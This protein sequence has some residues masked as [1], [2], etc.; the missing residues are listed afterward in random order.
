[1]RFGS[2]WT[3]LGAALV[4]VLAAACGGGGSTGDRATAGH[5]AGPTSTALG[6]V[7]GTFPLTGMPAYDRAKLARQAVAVKIDNS[8][9]A[10]PQ[11]GIDHADVVYEEYTEGITRFIVVFQSSDAPFVGPV[12]S[13]RPADPT[14]IKPLGGPLA[15]SGGSPAV[16]DVVKSS[17]IRQITENDT[18]TLK[19]RSGKSTPH[20]LYTTTAD[21]FRKAG[22]GA[23]PPAFAPFLPAGQPF[24]GAGAAPVTRLSLSPAPGVSAAYQWDAASKTWKRSTDGKPH[25]L[26]GGGQIAPT[27]II[28]QYTPYSTFP[29]DK[30]VRYPEV[31]GSGDA[32]V[33]SGGAMVK[34]KWTKSTAGSVTTYVDAAGAPVKLAPG[35]TWV[36][37]QEPG[38]GL[39]TA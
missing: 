15:F 11:A 9:D 37:L 4:L 6:P 38:G 27:N 30:K 26:E 25:A 21:L 19:R 34:A 14:V 18:D 33:F 24:A 5:P 7:V 32:L 23:P 22:A 31:L 13:V 20:N 17:G 8:A 39:T 35:Q 28:V 10:R 36:H 16:V 2:R 12:R 1:M 3:A 29:Q